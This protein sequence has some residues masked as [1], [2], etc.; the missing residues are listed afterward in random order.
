MR[1]LVY[2]LVAAIV[3]TLP[4]TINV[5]LP[6]KLHAAVG[7]SNPP[8]GPISDQPPDTTPYTRAVIPEDA[9]VGLP[10]LAPNTFVA[11]VVVNN[12]NTSLKN[13]DTANDGEPSIAVNSSNTSQ[14]AITAF[15]GSWGANAPVWYSTDSGNTWTEEFTVPVP[16]NV[17]SANGC[18]CDQAV[19]YTR[20]NLL[21]GT[22]LTF[23][24]TDVYTGLTSDPTN[25][26]SWNWLTSGGTA[27]KTNSSGAGNVDQPWLLVNRDTAT[28]SQDNMYV[29]YDDFT[30][31][32]DM[33]V[34]VSLGA[35]PPNFT[36]D[37]QSGSSGG[38]GIINP[39]HRLATDPRNGWVYDLFQQGNGNGNGTVDTSTGSYNIKYFL[40]RSTDGGQTW[41]LNGG[42]SVQ[43]VQADSQQ[44]INPGATFSMGNCT[45]ANPYKFGTVNALLGGVDHAA[46]D[47]NNGDVYYVYG[48]RDSVTGNN[49]ISIIRL[50]DTNNATHDLMAGSSNFVT[51]QIQAALPSVAV[52]TNGVVGVLYT[53]YN[54]MSGGFPQFSAHLALSADQ[55]TTF[56]NDIT[57]ETFL[58]PA[59]DAGTNGCRQRVLGDYQQVKAVGTTFN[60]VF[61]GN[62]NQF[63]RSSSNND[64]IFFRYFAGCNGITCPAPVIHSTDPNVCTAVV[65]YSAPTS[66]GDCGPVSC[67]PPSG[68]TFNKGVTTV[69]CTAQSGSMCTFTVTVVDTQAPSITCPADFKTTAGASCPIA[70]G[71]AVTFASPTVSDNCPGVTFA[72][73][74]PSGSVFG[75]GTTTVTCT[76][77]DTSGNQSSCTFN[78]TVF[79]FC[80]QDETNTGNFVLVNA[81][82]GQYDFFCNGVEIASGTGTLTAKGCQGT[83]LHVKGDRRV[84]MEWDTAAEGKGKGTAIVQ[85]GPNNTKCQITDKSMNDN[86]C[87]AP[88]QVVAPVEGKPGKRQ[89]QN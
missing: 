84:N 50:T 62:G 24:P 41:G 67:N 37:N 65:N 18:P 49:R 11:D 71:K 89:S 69:T 53:Q 85:L 47:P 19:D 3:S 81:N 51:G 8:L 61:T 59:T 64:P 4:L 43:V 29:A 46:V 66:S 12:T 2:I 55:G 6:E 76:A 20:G 86:T 16:P 88:P 32:P 10:V 40:T 5:V 1:R 28:A 13:T 38:S 14:M 33:R 56:P 73:N 82:T 75:V 39:G 78:V 48:N 79:S 54:G 25:S 9:A 27:V 57:L 22:F 35:N 87:T 7:Q 34:A 26:G 45:S 31:A 44:G 58:S 17:P 15:S 36:R 30:G 70:A 74:P 42:G 68:S 23:K 21:G 83:I 80:L 52:T 63:G 72:C 60:G 77:T